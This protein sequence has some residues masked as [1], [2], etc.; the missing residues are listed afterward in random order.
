MTLHP[1]LEKDT[2]VIGKLP[3]CHV[4]LMNDANYPWL[5]LVPAGDE[6]TEIYHL[7]EDDQ[8]QLAKESNT[9]LAWMSKEFNADKMNVAALGNVV[10]Q[11]H[12]HHIAR[13]TNDPAWPAPVW[14]KVKASPYNATDLN[15]MLE[16][17]R[18][19]LQALDLGFTISD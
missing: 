11:L 9:V 16:K 5:I 19:G 8:S 6:V 7:S 4:L 13:Y 10:P 18:N 15:T 2:I 3:L 1:Q 12:I 14:G 17:C